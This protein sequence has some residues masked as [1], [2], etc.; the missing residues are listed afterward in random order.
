MYVPYSP[1]VYYRANINKYIKKQ[2]LLSTKETVYN[3]LR[4]AH[5]AATGYTVLPTEVADNSLV[6]KKQRL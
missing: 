1:L 6:I 4:N 2:R 5:E 3:L